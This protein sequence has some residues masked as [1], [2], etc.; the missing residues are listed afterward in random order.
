MFKESFKSVS[1]LEGSC[2]KPRRGSHGQPPGPPS[3]L[4][5]VHGWQPAVY[6]T[7]QLHGSPIDITTSSFA[8][9]LTDKY[10][11]PL[12]IHSFRT[13]LSSA[14]FLLAILHPTQTTS[15]TSPHLH[16][17][18]HS[19]CPT[20][21]RSSS[22][23]PTMSR[24]PLVCTA[25]QKLK[26]TQTDSFTERVVAERSMLI[27]NMIEDLGNPGEEPIPI[28]NVRHPTL[29][30]SLSQPLTPHTGQRDRTAQGPRMVRAP[31]EGPSTNNR[32]RQRQPQEDDRD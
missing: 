17:T 11:R 30:L 8:T 12:S 2:A 14:L 24:S 18:T 19:Q 22:S 23:A 31:Q 6:L 9:L 10:L 29:P 21:R 16:H 20:I 15:D 1:S 32:R 7:V 4:M 3:T 28:M 27:K 5:S 13:S 25:P 26:H